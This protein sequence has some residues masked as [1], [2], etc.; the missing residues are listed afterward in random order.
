[1]KINKNI[2]SKYTVINVFH[3]RTLLKARFTNSPILVGNADYRGIM[4]TFTVVYSGVKCREINQDDVTRISRKMPCR[5]N[6][7]SLH[8]PTLLSTVAYRN[9]M[10]CASKSFRDLFI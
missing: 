10:Y 3:T 4:R 5:S 2:S 1:M 8:I 7:M 9:V 6:V